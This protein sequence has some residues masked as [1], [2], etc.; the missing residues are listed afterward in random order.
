MTNYGDREDTDSQ[1]CPYGTAEGARKPDTELPTRNP[2]NRVHL[3][4][5]QW[6]IWHERA[7]KLQGGG[8]V[9]SVTKYMEGME[10]LSRDSRG[11]CCCT[12]ACLQ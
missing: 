8:S 1:G 6:F 3:G 2:E 10:H 5:I 4:S 12:H 9:M 7:P 11:V